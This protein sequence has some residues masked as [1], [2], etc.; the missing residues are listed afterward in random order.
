MGLED[1]GS[2]LLGKRYFNAFKSVSCINHKSQL[3]LMNGR[4]WFVC[5]PLR[6]FL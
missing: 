4:V 2:I 6:E 1:A 5:R 3:K